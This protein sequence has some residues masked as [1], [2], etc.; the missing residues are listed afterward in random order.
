MHRLIAHLDKSNHHRL[1]RDISFGQTTKHVG[2]YAPFALRSVLYPFSSSQSI[3]LM[4]AGDPFTYS[5][6][7]SDIGAIASISGRSGPSASLRN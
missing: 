3:C 4:N 7:S 1:P 5:A 2:Y 6:R